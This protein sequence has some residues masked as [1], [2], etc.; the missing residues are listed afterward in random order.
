MRHLAP[1]TPFTVG[2]LVN[3]YNKGTLGF[4][5]RR[6][7]ISFCLPPE[8]AFASVATL[9]AAGAGYGVDIEVWAPERRFANGFLFGQAGAE[10]DP[11]S[12]MKDRDAVKADLTPAP[13]TNEAA[14]LTNRSCVPMKA[15]TVA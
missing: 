6:G 3:I 4:L 15:R 1:G 9:A 7:G 8:L 12:R 14:F 5:A 13:A 11:S 2:P 10:W